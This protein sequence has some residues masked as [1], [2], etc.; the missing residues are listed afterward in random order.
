MLRRMSDPYAQTPYGTSGNPSS[1]VAPNEVQTAY[2]LYIAN[3]VI[4]VISVILTF[5]L[6]PSLI[7][8]QLAKQG[9]TSG[10]SEDQLQSAAQ[11]GGIAALVFGLILLALYLFFVFKMRAGRN[12]ARIVLAVLSAIS[13]ISTLIGIGSI[14]MLFGLGVLG[15]LSGI[16]S[17]VQ[18][19]LLIAAVY[20]MFRPA[21]NAYF[22]SGRRGVR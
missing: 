5:F 4:G 17:L 1:T 8:A 15:A 13:I 18:L 12:W 6:L 14:G 11:I 22:S 19:L 3:I 16:L 20:F 7:G 2:K 10:L 21:A 9:N